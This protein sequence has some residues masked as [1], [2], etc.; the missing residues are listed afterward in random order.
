MREKAHCTIYILLQVQYRTFLIYLVK[1]LHEKCTTGNKI[2]SHET[3]F[4]F[5]GKTL[6]DF[7]TT[8]EYSFVWKDFIISSGLAYY[9]LKII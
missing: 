7:S 2:F 1:W 6:T 3:T 8:L 5:K 4:F 9:I